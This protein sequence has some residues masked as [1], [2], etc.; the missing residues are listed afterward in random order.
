MDEN[1]NSPP[2]Q[3]SSEPPVQASSEPVDKC[4]CC[5]AEPPDGVL[6]LEVDLPLCL[7]CGV[8]AREHIGAS[9]EGLQ[10]VARVLAAILGRRVKVLE[11]DGEVVYGRAARSARVLVQ[12]LTRR[13]RF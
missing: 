11:L 10:G 12:P 4:V 5:S 3:A 2:V 7:A 8:V 6:R 13:R 1:R 9:A